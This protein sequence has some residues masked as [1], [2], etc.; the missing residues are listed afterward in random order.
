MRRVLLTS[1]TNPLTVG[2]LIGLALA[3]T[4]VQLPEPIHAPLELLGQLAVP[5]MLIAYGIALR[6][7]PGLGSGVAGQLWATTLLK[8]FVQPFVA[9]AVAHWILGVDGPPLLAIVVTAALPTAQ[10]I[11]VHATRFNTATG[12]ARD[13]ILLTTLGSVPIILLTALWLA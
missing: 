13:T 6:L 8:L 9:Y 11:F 7:G 2:S 4:G 12:L 3:L 5:A 10:N 1:L